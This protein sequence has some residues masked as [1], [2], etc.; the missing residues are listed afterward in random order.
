M[1]RV[2]TRA[3]PASDS[4]SRIVI[5]EACRLLILN[6]RAG[7]TGLLIGQHIV[8]V[9]VTG[10]PVDAASINLES[11]TLSGCFLFAVLQ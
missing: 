9:G 1:I 5:F 7:S 6:G 4:F 8:Q 11:V 3:K 2:L 10:I